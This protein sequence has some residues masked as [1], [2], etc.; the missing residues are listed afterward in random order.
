MITGTFNAKV[1]QPIV[2][3]FSRIGGALKGVGV[4]FAKLN[5][6]VMKGINALKN[7]GSNVKG[8]FFGFINNVKA[9]FGKGGGL[10]KALK[11]K[12]DG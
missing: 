12:A 1:I 8:G 5:P 6:E 10:S 9:F 4:K 2:G 11:P 7:F 3:F